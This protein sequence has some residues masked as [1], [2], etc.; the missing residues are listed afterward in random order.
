MNLDEP[1]FMIYL[2]KRP[3]ALIQ[4]SSLQILLISV[5]RTKLKKPPWEVLP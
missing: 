1:Y 2:A 4:L 5:F 3:A